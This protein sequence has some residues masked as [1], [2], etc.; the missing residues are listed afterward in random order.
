MTRNIGT[1]DHPHLVKLDS[2][3]VHNPRPTTSAGKGKHADRSESERKRVEK[4]WGN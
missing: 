1:K 4:I 2:G 3:C